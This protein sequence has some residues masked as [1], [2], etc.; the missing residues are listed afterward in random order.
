VTSTSTAPAA[1]AGVVTETVVTERD[2]TAAATPSKVTAVVL[3][4]FVPVRVTDVP[5]A[6][7]P[8]VGEAWVSVGG[9]T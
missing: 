1:C 2:V 3:E 6:V 9:S 5:P 4:R 8:V 7:V